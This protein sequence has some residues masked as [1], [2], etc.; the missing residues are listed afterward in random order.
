MNRKKSSVSGPLHGVKILDLTTVV[1]GPAATQMLGDMGADVIKIES[2]LGD[3]MRAIGPFK[4]PG[5]GPLFFQCNR[6]KRSVVLDLKQ[7]ADKE[8]LW[9]LAKQCDVVVSNIRPQALERLG[10]SYARLA[11]ENPGVIFC[12]AVGYGTDGPYCGQAVYDDLM[13]SASGISGLFGEVD[14]APRYAPINICDRVVGL[15][16]SSAILAALVHCKSTGEG[17]EIEVPMFETMAQ[18]VLGDHLGGAA[19]SPSE[20]PMKYKRLMSRTRGPYPTQ[21]GHLSLVV[22]TNKHWRAFT[23]LVG[24]PDL[25]D[26]DP[27]FLDQESRTQNAEAMGQYLQTHLPQ[28]S[29]AEWTQV[30]RA[31]DIPVA[32]VNSV[33]SLFDDEHL[34]A[35]GLFEEIEHPTE[36]LLRT[37]RFPIR[38]GKTPA[39]IRRLAPNLGEHNA[40]VFQEFNV[41]HTTKRTAV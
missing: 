26:R 25:L 35:V 34:K 24:E 15:H 18:F 29:N 14:G 11:Q 20:G 7:E 40:E 6:N 41:P 13:Q 39:S 33:E 4:N 31:N 22:Y 21:D 17:Q 8:A 1:M 19:F 5:M 9:A 36:G 3:T 27:R 10:I 2:P 38:F 37:T 32:P 16:I 28:R 23:K 12:S 30:L